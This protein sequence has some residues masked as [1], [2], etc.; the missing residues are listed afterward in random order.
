MILW[1]LPEMKIDLCDKTMYKKIGGHQHIVS[2]NC[3]LNREF[4]RILIKIE[5]S[6]NFDQ[7]RIF[8]KILNQI[9][10]FENFV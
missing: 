7:N 8:S 9:E 4:R 2:E 1:N 6:E 10:I 3:N 5:V